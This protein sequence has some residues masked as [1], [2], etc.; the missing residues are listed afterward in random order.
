MG[1]LLAGTKYR[2][3]FEERLKNILEE[4]K[5]CGNIILFLD[6]VHTLVGAGGATDG[7]VAA[8]NILKP[9]LARGEVQ[10]GI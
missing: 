3:D 10:V 2:G 8:A 5:L 6:E 1:H 4:I 7:A 9:A